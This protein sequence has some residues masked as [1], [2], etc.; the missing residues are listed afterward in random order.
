MM[1]EVEEITRAVGLVFATG[2]QETT[3]TMV[4]EEASSTGVQ[5]TS[6]SSMVMGEAVDSPVLRGG[7]RP[8]ARVEQELVTGVTEV[9]EQESTS[10]S[11][12]GARKTTKVEQQATDRATGVEQEQATMKAKEVGVEGQFVQGLLVETSGENIHFPSLMQL[13]PR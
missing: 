7:P 8:M 13:S 9:T 10:I 2:E 11:R 1:T 4:V 3:S 5:G 12:G 6:T